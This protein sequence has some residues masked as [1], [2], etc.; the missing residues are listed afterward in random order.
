MSVFS[1]CLIQ[2]IYYSYPWSSR[3]LF[4][5]F[6][7]CFKKNE[8]ISIV[9]PNWSWKTTLFH[10][11][12]NIKTPSKWSITRNWLD[13]SYVFQDYR[14]ALF[15]WMT[16]Y[17]NITYPLL[18]AW[19]S[20]AKRQK[21]LQDIVAL[22]PIS[23]SMDSYPYELSWWQQ[24]LV[25]IMRS[26]ISSPDILLLD[27]PFASLDND[28]KQQLYAFLSTLFDHTNMWII[29]ISHDQKEVFQLSHRV[30]E[31]QQTHLKLL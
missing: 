15:P 31:L 28:I 14:N 6:S 4:E 20:V 22:C 27:E 7:H 9:W 10:L 5:W 24:Q 13:F 8:W 29:M 12:A 30:Y 18:I 2:N 25:C 17:D 19:H 21:I 23:I 11:L 3:F 1:E 26:V 16:V